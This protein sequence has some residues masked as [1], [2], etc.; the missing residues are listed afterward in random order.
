MI[1]NRKYMKE[2][3]RECKYIVITASV[4]GLNSLAENQS[5]MLNICS[6]KRPNLKKKTKNWDWFK[7]KYWKI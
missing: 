5:I 2:I 3:Q 7:I 1:I 6:Y 4:N